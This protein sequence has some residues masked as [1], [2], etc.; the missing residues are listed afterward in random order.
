MRIDDPPALAFRKHN[1]SSCTRAALAA[2]QARCAEQKLR[3][4]PVRVRVLELLLESHKALGAYS[5][6][7]R[8]RAE[9]RCSHPPVAYRAL[10]FLVTHGFAHKIERLNAF[11][12][13]ARPD[14]KADASH[15]P[16]FMIC[17]K[18][19]HVAEEI[20]PAANG[21]LGRS[22]RALGFAIECTVIEAEGICP[23]C[24]DTLAP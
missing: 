15:Q 23:A 24:R 20:A 22:A 17:R 21:P 10:D 13:C 7:D 1:H 8:L 6:L 14:P 3:L 4:T 11:V 19:E 9:D 5:I 16:A 12:A 18:C 2:A